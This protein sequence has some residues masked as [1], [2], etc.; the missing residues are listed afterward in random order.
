[1]PAAVKQ[2]RRDADYFFQGMDEEIRRSLTTKQEWEIKK[3]LNCAIGRPSRKI[4]D[5]RFSIPLIAARYFFVLFIGRDRRRHKRIYELPG[6]VR[7]ANYIFGMFILACLI[8]A[9]AAAVL[10]LLYLVKCALGVDIFPGFSLSKHF[11]ALF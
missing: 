7:T 6:E 3:A 4:V 11:K 2:S 8:S 10:M 1:M 9:S 5:I